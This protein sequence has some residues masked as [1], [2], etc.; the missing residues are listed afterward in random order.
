MCDVLIFPADL[1]VVGFDVADARSCGSSTV[2]HEG[3]RYSDNE[4]QRTAVL[5]VSDEPAAPDRVTVHRQARRQPQ[6]RGGSWNGPE[7]TWSCQVDWSVSAV[8]VCFQFQFCRQNSSLASERPDLRD[9]SSVS[10]FLK[11]LEMSGNSA[12]VRE[13]AQSQG[14]VRNLCSQG[15]LIVASDNKITYLYLICTV[16][17][18]S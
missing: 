9:L 14:K 15:N 3:W 2:W 12:K 13:K 8:A 7:R 1:I 4:P 5:P 17:H 18:F 16:I 11:F 6:R 10:T